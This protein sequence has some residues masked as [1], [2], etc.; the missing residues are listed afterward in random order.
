M[1][2]SLDF[3]YFGYLIMVLFYLIFTFFNVSHLLRYGLITIS[4]ILVVIFF[5]GI[6]L[7]ILYVSWGYISQIN[8]QKTVTIPFSLTYK[9]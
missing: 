4:N 9:E 7:L 1:T 8:W 3:F 5:L 6:S 2:I